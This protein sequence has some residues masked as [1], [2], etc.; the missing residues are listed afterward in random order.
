[1]RLSQM[2]LPKSSFSGAAPGALLAALAVM[3][4]G[5]GQAD[6]Q[7][8]QERQA[9]AQAGDG[10]LAFVIRDWFTSVYNTKFMDE[11]PEGLSM[12]ND[13]IW[14]RSLSKEQ[15]AKA[16]GNGL[17]QTLNRMGIAMQRGPNGENVC[18][19][20]TVVNDPPMKLVEG[21]L[22]YGFDL[23]G[24]AEGKATPKSCPH[25]NFTHPDGTRGIDNQLYR[26]LGCTAGWRRG[27]NVDL[28]AHQGRGT[29]GL[30][31]IL[32]EITGVKDPRNSENVTVT[33]YRSVDQFAVDGTGRPLPFSSYNIDME[34]DKPRYGDSL[35]GS[36]RNG[37]LITEQ[38]D[39]RLPW[40]GNYNFM[41]PVVRDMKLQLKISEDGQTAT[42]TIGGYYPMDDFLYYIAGIPG[43]DAAA[44]NCPSMYV[45]AR[46]V[47]DGY[48]DPETGQC[49][50]LSAAFE[51]G[52]YAAYVI[53]PTRQQT[54]QRR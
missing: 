34:G 38:G 1:M 20:P 13:E 16:T 30:G 29:S 47:A 50:H 12:S 21:E 18:M 41:N 31:M 35:K 52:A 42:G 46:E 9:S 54:A 19:H 24:D 15:R 39:V 4:T 27:G 25:V 49:T 44:D 8:A 40:Y 33:F 11:C 48:P 36:I 51:I 32:I 53:H 14:W 26:L 23:D 43:H 2:A 17:V 37:E 7:R 10:K 22:S 5:C 3:L 45:A 28:N 6:A